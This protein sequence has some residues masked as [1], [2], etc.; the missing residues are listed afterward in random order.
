ML[1]QSIHARLAGKKRKVHSSFFRSVLL[2]SNTSGF[3][4]LAILL[5]DIPEVTD[6]SVASVIWI[7]SEKL[8]RH[9][10]T[11]ALLVPYKVSHDDGYGEKLRALKEV[12]VA[13]DH[14][15]L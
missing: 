14:L 5:Q 8:R 7:L 15:F 4:G 2:F 1:W 12:L 6:K 13:P 11:L 3:D 9:S 10:Y